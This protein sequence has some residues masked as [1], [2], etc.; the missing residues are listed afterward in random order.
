VP[1]TDQAPVPT[2]AV[3]MG[4]IVI[5]LGALGLLGSMGDM[6][7]GVMM[8]TQADM[9]KAMNESVSTYRRGGGPGPGKMTESMEKMFEIPE[10]YNGF[11][12]SLGIL[13]LLVKG[14]YIASG[15]LMLT[16]KPLSL[17]LFYGGTACLLAMGV[18]EIAAAV[19]AGSFMALTT[20]P[21]TAVGIF[22]DVGVLIC[23]LCFDKTYFREREIA[24]YERP[25]EPE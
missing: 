7:W 24:G 25:V 6:L 13:G 19:S 15:I 2:W 8:D 4:I 14:T 9:M 23:V 5:A 20:I 18:T 16:G 17:K 21:W 10:W 12:L 3:T 11:M 1:P 22:I